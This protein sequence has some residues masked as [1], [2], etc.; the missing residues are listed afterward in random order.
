LDKQNGRPADVGAELLRFVRVRSTI[1][2]RSE[3]RAS[4]GFAIPARPLA[5][6]HFVV[7]GSCQLRV[8][9]VA[10]PL[11]LTA[12]DVA[13]IPTGRAH[14]ARSDADATV[15]FLD[16]ILAANPPRDGR[17]SYG[18]SGA[19][20]DIV[21]GGF[22]FTDP[23]A[24]PI[25]DLLPSVLVLRGEDRAPNR[26]VREVL[27]LLLRELQHKDGATET[28]VTRLTDA[29]LALAVRAAFDR[30]AQV[31][32][33]W[34]DRDI[35]AAVAAID[36]QPERHWSLVELA[37]V[38]TLSRSAF[39]GR[40]AAA[41]GESPMRYVSRARLARGAALLRDGTASVKHVAELTGF[42]SEAS[43]SRAFR[44]HFGAAPRDYRRDGRTPLAG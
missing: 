20:T 26:E 36:A 28:V 1:W 3:M 15:L 42:R 8:D 30:G 38:A 13:I 39:A 31:P 41:T 29:L 21:C 14:T 25:L 19:S 34:R 18:G 10:E 7:A 22:E 11:V 43:F 5:A 37:S 33:T 4:W 16:D 27:A 23:T 6:F 35:A 40:F 24:Q 12:G 17:L 32:A 44:R 9:G 2:C